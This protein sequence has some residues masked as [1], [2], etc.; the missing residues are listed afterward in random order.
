M[1]YLP[2]RLNGRIRGCG[3]ASL[4]DSP[5]VAAVG[6][7]GLLPSDLAFG[8]HGQLASG[9]YGFTG[10]SIPSSLRLSGWVSSTMVAAGAAPACATL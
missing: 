1:P 4:T 7:S 3:P 9:G 8:V 10:R 6:V 2:P 5:H